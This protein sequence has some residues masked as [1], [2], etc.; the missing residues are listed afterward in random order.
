[1]RAYYKRQFLNTEENGGSAHVE[2]S[3]YEAESGSSHSNLSASFNISDC[4]R[5][6]ELDFS[7]YDADSAENVRVKMRRLRLALGQFEKALEEQI[8]VI[9]RRWS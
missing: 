5:I 6:I 1:M 2:A 3:V 7:V 4:N 9:S 8:A